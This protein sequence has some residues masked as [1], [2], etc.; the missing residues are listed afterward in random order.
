MSGHWKALDRKNFTS[1]SPPL[2][3]KYEI[4]SSNYMVYLSDMVH[5][6]TEHLTARDIRRRALNSDTSIDPS[7]DQGQMVQFLNCVKDALSQKSGTS[8]ELDYTLSTK[9][10]LLKTHT[11]LPGRL[12]PLEWFLELQLAAP[13]VLTRELIVPLLHV[14]ALQQAESSS[15]CQQ[16]KEKDAIIDKLV[17]TLVSEGTAISKVFPGAAPSRSALQSNPRQALSKYARSLAK[18]NEHQWRNDLSNSVAQMSDFDLLLNNTLLPDLSGFPQQM[19]VPDYGEWWLHLSSIE[20]PG[21]R[22]QR[23][24]SFSK[25]ESQDSASDSQFQVSPPP[26]P[27]T[28]AFDGAIATDSKQRQPT[29]TKPATKPASNPTTVAAFTDPSLLSEASTT[30]DDDTET[31]YNPASQPQNRTQMT[32]DRSPIS[33]PN[34][35]NS[36]TPPSPSKRK[37]S[38]KTSSPTT[39]PLPQPITRRPKIGQIGGKAKLPPQPVLDPSNGISGI[40]SSP[41]HPHSLSP[42]PSSVLPPTRFAEKSN[43][44]TED[45][46]APQPSASMT[47]KERADANRKA[48][49][50]HMEEAAT[51]KAKAAAKKRRF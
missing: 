49:K 16:L 32:T 10:L 44:P 50:R 40:P 23:K 34:H 22:G 31:K 21:T 24:P 37:A 12:Q 43:Q 26:S 14:Q 11:P 29:P 25:K 5:V 6:W 45:A 51:A 47:E 48:V 27:F 38:P 15:L 18:F 42:P 33:L 1:N 36:F 17:D 2:L 13:F 3:I 4:E 39:S 30:D 41:H 28:L 19:T 46:S 35:K 9:S 20:N 7:E 8:L